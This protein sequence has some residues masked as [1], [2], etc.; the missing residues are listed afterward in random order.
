MPDLIHEHAIHVRSPEGMRFIP[1]TYGEERTDGT[2][3]GWIEFVPADDSSTALRTDRETSQPNRRAL[4][5]WST[6]L[7]AVYLEGAFERAR[8]VPTAT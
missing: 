2:W 6:G 4:E 3:I 5:Y 1:R 7:E 8:L